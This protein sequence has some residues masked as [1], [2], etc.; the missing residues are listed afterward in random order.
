MNDTIDKA[1]QS[2]DWALVLTLVVTAI[3]LGA[4]VYG[5]KKSGV[6]FAREIAANV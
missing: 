1:K 4:V 3:I 2:V 5:M 6:K